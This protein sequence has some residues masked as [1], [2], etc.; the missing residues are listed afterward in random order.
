MCKSDRHETMPPR[1]WEMDEHTCIKTC[2]KSGLV[3]TP[4]QCHF[5]ECRRTHAKYATAAKCAAACFDPCVSVWVEV[6]ASSVR[7][8]TRLAA[9]YNPGQWDPEP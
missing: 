9:K 1:Y 3:Y 5:F 8:C 4:G 6:E 2:V 7:E